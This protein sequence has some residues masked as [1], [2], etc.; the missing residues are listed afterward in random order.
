MCHCTRR[1]YLHIHRYYLESKVHTTHII[2]FKHNKKKKY[3]M[4]IP[5]TKL[6]PK[7]NQNAI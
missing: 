4:I 2:I 6:L 1:V 7:I 5:V 3:N